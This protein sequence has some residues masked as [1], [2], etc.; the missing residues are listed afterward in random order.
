MVVFNYIHSKDVFQKFYS[1]M[2]AKRLVEHLSMSDEAE[3]S[4]L[5]RLKVLSIISLTR[6]IHI[7]VCWLL[8]PPVVVRSYGF[9]M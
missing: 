7:A 2:L 6:F 1:N 8:E 4:M 5:A 9:F 3:A